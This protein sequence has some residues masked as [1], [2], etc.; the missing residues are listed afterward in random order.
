MGI[1]CEE[2]VG[3]C[4]GF[5]V[6]FG[7]LFFLFVLFVFVLF[8]CFF[9]FFFFFFFFFCAIRSRHPNAGPSRACRPVVCPG[10]RR[11]RLAGAPGLKTRWP[12]PN[13]FQP[14]RAGSTVRETGGD[15]APASPSTRR[16]N[17]WVQSQFQG[18][19]AGRQAV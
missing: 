19:T 5:L 6:W 16:R 13:L 14:R 3:G 1:L 15:S 12:Q 10:Q 4:V 11:A 7:V 8:C 2:V 9:G 17:Q 18:R